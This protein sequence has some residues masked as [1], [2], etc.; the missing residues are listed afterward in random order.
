VRSTTKLPSTETKLTETEAALAIVRTWLAKASF[1]KDPTNES[2]ERIQ[3]DGPAWDGE[4]FVFVRVIP[5]LDIDLVYI[6]QLDIDL[7]IDGK[8]RDGITVEATS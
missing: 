5:Q 1:H 8:H 4:Y 7:V 2:P 6:P 3:I